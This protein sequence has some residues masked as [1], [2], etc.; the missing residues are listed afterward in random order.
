MEAGAMAPSGL[1]EV[2]RARADGRW[3]KA[4]EGQRSA[5]PP[6]DFIEALEGRP[7]AKAFY[8]TL[9]S[10]NRYAIYYRIQ[11]SKRE[12]TRARRIAK[13]VDMLERGEKLH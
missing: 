4:Y 11:D 5:Q 9:N 8:E 3:D 6:A 10:V 13:F 1:A 2:E 7:A 12:D